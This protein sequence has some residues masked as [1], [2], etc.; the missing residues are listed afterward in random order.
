MG[1][2]SG[3]KGP[4]PKPVAARFWAKTRFADPPDDVAHLGQCM[5]WTG[6]TQRGGYG[7]FGLGR[8]DGTVIAHRF[9]WFLIHGSY[10]DLQLDHLCRVRECVNPAHLEPVTPGE[11]VRRAAARVTHCPK[12]H[13]YTLEN[14]YI[15][16][17]GSRKCRACWA[18]WRKPAA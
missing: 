13:E 4:D 12:G 6:A 8:Q 11:N 16:A 15:T 7:K 3:K 14:T 2:R 5:I 9:A 1:I 17:V 18:R 10:P